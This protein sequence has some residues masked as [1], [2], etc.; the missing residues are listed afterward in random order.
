MPRPLEMQI[1][2]RALMKDAR[3]KAHVHATMQGLVK[4]GEAPSPLLLAALDAGIKAGVTA[5]IEA[6]KAAYPEDD[7]VKM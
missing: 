1:D 5:L 7:E 3:V 2:Q 6:L 4:L